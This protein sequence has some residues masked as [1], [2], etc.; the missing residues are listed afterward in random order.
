MCRQSKNRNCCSKRLPLSMTRC[1]GR[2]IWKA[3]GA[4][5]CSSKVTMGREGIGARLL[6]RWEW[7]CVS[8][9]KGRREGSAARQPVPLCTGAGCQ[10]VPV[11]ADDVPIHHRAL[12]A[13]GARGRLCGMRVIKVCPTDSEDYAE[14]NSDED[15]HNETPFPT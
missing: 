3:L 11:V 10:A 1:P 12:R 4:C 13:R 2:A 8:N 6:T 14:D 7:G 5:L 15:A 9:S